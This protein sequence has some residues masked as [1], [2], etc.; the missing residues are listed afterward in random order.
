MHLQSANKRDYKTVTVV[1]PMYN[2]ERYIDRFVKSVLAQDYPKES[3][4]I[5]LIDGMSTD[6]TR[7]IAA[8]YTASHSHIRLIDN[9]EKTVSY[10]LNRGISMSGGEVIIRLDAHCEYPSNYISRLVDE[11]F[12]LDADNVGGLWHTLPADGSAVCTAIAIGSS[13]LFGVGGS[14]HKIGADRIMEV[15]TVPFGCYRRDV[16]DRIG[17]FDEELVRN[18]DDE[19][20]ARLINNGGRIYIIPDVVIDY[21]AR[22]SMTKMRKMY[23]QYGLFKPLVNKK[24]GAPATIRQFFPALF[25]TGVVLGLPLALLFRP[26]MYLYLSVIAL[27]LLIGLLIGTGYGARLGKPALPLLIPYT[28]LNIHASYGI[29]YI[30]GIYKVIAHKKFDVKPN[31]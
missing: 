1:C 3:L 31:R 26:I 4:E 19:F 13:H 11:L 14:T 8:G 6:R 7:Q 29:G 21:T 30:C 12:R 17:R 23:F 24:L 22:D 9:P 27:Y 20:N 5:L 28:F 15:D 10:A 2:E 16:F 25:V 18:Q